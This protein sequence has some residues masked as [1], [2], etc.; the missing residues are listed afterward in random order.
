LRGEEKYTRSIAKYV[1]AT[2]FEDLPQEAIAKAKLHILDAIGIMLCAYGTG[3]RLIKG[4]ME[5]AAESGGNDQATVLGE[6]RK[7]GC[8]DAAMVNSVMAN[9]LDSSDGHFLGGHINDRLV[10]VALAAAE[11]VGASGR[12]LLTAITLGYEIYI[13]L[14]STLFGKVEPAMERPPHF[15]MLGTLSGI[16]PAGKLL[17]LDEEQLAGAMGLAASTQLGGTQYVLSGGHEKDLCP[18]HEIR[19]ALFSTLVAE[20]G[21]LGSTDIL[22]GERGIFK[23]IGVQPQ[24]IPELGMEYRITECYIKPY[25]ACRYLHASIEAALNLVREHGISASEVE[26]AIVT[27]NTSSARRVSYEIKSHVNAIFSHAYQ[28]AAVLRYGRVDLPIT[29]EE[30]IS[31]PLF[32]ILL[33]RIEV[34][35]DPE[36][37]RLYQQR[38][39]DQPPWPAEV[40]VFM[41][42]GKRYQS[43]VLSPRGDP[44]NPLT[45]EEVKQKFIR[46]TEDTLSKARA[47][48]VIELVDQLETVSTVDKLIELLV[49]K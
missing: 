45:P 33:P 11:R 36:Y 47:T 30:K 44:G 13:H 6:G 15:V 34:R 40:E 5:L 43:K 48:E 31:D 21:I 23:T 27:T 16:V 41:Q 24:V 17:G 10:P 35:A 2:E 37:D 12:D 42:D 46:F 26:K 18:G 49:V 9:F 22:E 20:K 8:L 32:K 7:V 28:V 39:L 29:W 25:P 1:A 4:L 3:H 19:R 38:S 14:A